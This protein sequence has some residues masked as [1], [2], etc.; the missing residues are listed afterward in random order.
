[1][2][3]SNPLP[4]FAGGTF[5]HVSAAEVQVSKLA[6]SPVWSANGIPDQ[7]LSEPLAPPPN[8]Y[9]RYHIETR[10]TP[11]IL[12]LPSRFRVKVKMHRLIAMVLKDLFVVKAHF[13]TL[14]TCTCVP[15]GVPR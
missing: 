3:M 7:S 8:T 1:M 4:L 11:D 14:L 9:H 13:P 5:K 2:T 12:P 6:S 15:V 10:T